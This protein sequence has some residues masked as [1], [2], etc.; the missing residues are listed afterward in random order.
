MGT[1][2]FQYTDLVAAII[3]FAIAAVVLW[4]VRRLRTLGVPPVIWGFVAFFL[5][6][7]LSGLNEQ[8]GVP[9]YENAQLELGLDVASVAILVYLLANVGKLTRALL[10]T[11]READ[12]R[13]AEYNRAFRDYTQIVRHRVMNPL[14]AVQ[15]SAQTL[16]TGVITDPEMHT[17][18][19][20]VIIQMAEKV[21]HTTLEPERRDALERDLDAVPHGVV[22]D[23]AP[24]FAAL[25]SRSFEGIERRPPSERPS[26]R[27]PNSRFTE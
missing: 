18:L 21:K 6:R 19:C 12:F 10:A 27:R 20:D 26:L 5:V 14:T 8:A 16:K 24:S 17:Q 3:D 7:A 13:A 25:S 11:L 9:P 4:Q 23:A 1:G 22:D 15:G 2:M